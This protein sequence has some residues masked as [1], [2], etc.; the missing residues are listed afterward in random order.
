MHFFLVWQYLIQTNNKKYLISCV[1]LQKSIHKSG[2]K[3]KSIFFV[4]YASFHPHIKY[5]HKVQRTENYI[6]QTRE[7]DYWFYSLTSYVYDDCWP[8]IWCVRTV[9]LIF[10][11]SLKKNRNKCK[12]W[13]AASQAIYCFLINCINIFRLS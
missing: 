3:T 10:D 6:D 5:L 2:T 7:K 8:I 12:Y 9:K 1:T 13:S 11:R 4:I